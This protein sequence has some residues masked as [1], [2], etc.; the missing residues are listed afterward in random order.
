[1]FS[2]NLFATLQKIH[3]IAS[4]LEPHQQHQLGIKSYTFKI[5]LVRTMCFLLIDHERN[6]T[7]VRDKEVLEAIFLCLKYDVGNNGEFFL[8]L[9]RRIN[10]LESNCEIYF[11]I[12]ALQYLSSL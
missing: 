8:N 3:Q 4:T 6:Q 1:M 5:N 2:K 12:K 7:I 11:S 9:F 10:L